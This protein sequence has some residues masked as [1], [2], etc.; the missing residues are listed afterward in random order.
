MCDLD[1]HYKL[2]QSLGGNC[3][4]GFGDI[5][6][7]SFLR[8]M[9]QIVDTKYLIYLTVKTNVKLLNLCRILQHVNTKLS[10]KHDAL[11]KKEQVV[12][13]DMLLLTS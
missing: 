1:D 4:I 6:L 5:M 7:F 11:D 13:Q 10:P 3:Q 8:R 9:K 12:L 2:H